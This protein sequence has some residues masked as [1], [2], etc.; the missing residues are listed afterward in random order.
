MMRTDL[1]DISLCIG[2]LFANPFECEISQFDEVLEATAEA[3]FK[4]VSY[5]AMHQQLL[6]AAGE[7]VDRERFAKHG[8]TVRVVEA[9]MQWATGDRGLI[10]AEIGPLLDLASEMQAEHVMAV[11]MD[12][13]PLD[14]DSAADGLAYLADR[15]AVRGLRVSVEFLPWSSIADLA[16]AWS[17]VQRAA[18]ENCGIVLDT[19]HWQR[20]PGGPQLEL[21]ATIPGDRIHV[22]QLCDALASPHGELLDEAMHHRLLPGQGAVDFAPLLATLGQIGAEPIIAPEVFNPTLAAAGPARFAAD[23]SAATRALLVANGA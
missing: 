5:W 20:Q 7:R 18:H 3:G 13:G 15:A 19:W 9:A 6:A 2:P 14:L 17:L 1:E 4:G 8:L 11:T 16:T 22:L 23:I 12:A 10:D 21:L